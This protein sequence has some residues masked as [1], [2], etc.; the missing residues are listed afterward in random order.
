MKIEILLSE[1]AIS[2]SGGP[3][4]HAAAA[5]AQATSVRHLLE[6]PGQGHLPHHTLRLHRPLLCILAHPEDKLIEREVI[7]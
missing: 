5:A 3:H 2:P 1:L 6:Q 4:M 7:T